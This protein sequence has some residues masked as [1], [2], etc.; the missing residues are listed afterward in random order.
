MA[1]FEQ[2]YLV[3]GLSASAAVGVLPTVGAE[4]IL[5]LIALSLPVV[6]VLAF[7]KDRPQPALGWA[8]LTAGFGVLAAGELLRLLLDDRSAAAP[9]VLSLIAD[10]VQLVGLMMI[11]RSR[12]TGRSRSSW[13]DAAGVGVATFTAVWS[14]VHRQLRD[15]ADW[16]SV[17]WFSTLL[18]P[19]LGVALVAMAL[20][21]VLGERGGHRVFGGLAIAYALQT[22]ADIAAEQ[23]TH[24]GWLRVIGVA[25]ALAYVLFDSSLMR[26]G[27]L[28][29]PQQSPS[30]LVRR[31]AVQALALQGAVIVVAITAIVV[32]ARSLVPMPL[33]ASWATVG[34]V[35]LVLNR[36][37]VLA[38]IRM[39]GE[40]S[41]TENHRRLTALVDNSSEIIA[42]ADPDGVL[43]Y[44][45]SSVGAITGRPAE[46]WLGSN[47][48]TVL[49]EYLVGSEV[50]IDRLRSLMP[51]ERF[52]WESE[53]RAH[54]SS[55][56]RVLKFT[57][58]NHV[59]TPEVNGWVITAS[60]VTD[61]ARLTSE[62]RHQALHDTL[63]GLPNRALLFDRIEHALERARHTDH[64]VTSVALVDLDEFK[65]VNDSLGHDT[66]DVLL[67]D[68]AARLL[69]AVRPGDTVARLGGDEFALLMEGTTEAEALAIAQRAL[70]GLALPIQLGTV[71]F[72]ANAS[73]GLVCHRGSATPME[74][75][76]FAD[77]A[78][79]EAKRE[80]KA[81]VKVFREHMHNA[82]KNQLEMRMQL[83]AAIEHDELSVVYQPIVDTSEFRVCGVEALLRWT[84]PSRG[85]V[86]PSV[87]IPVAE[88]SGLLEQIGE[89]VLRKAC[90]D[91]ARWSRRVDAAYISVNVSAAQISS[92]GF[93]GK[94]MGALDHS[95]LPPSR[96]LLEVTETML[97][98]DDSLA[99][100]VLVQ[101]RQ[102]GVRIA[103][104]D[105][106]TGYSS[107]A[108][109]RQ[110]AVDV[111]K[112]DQTFVRD[113]DTNSDHQA[114]TRTMLTLASGL[115]MTAI[116]EGVETTDELAELRRMGC[117]YA[118]GYLFSYPVPADVLALLID[119]CLLDVPPV[120]VG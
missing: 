115:S 42:L 93:V 88:Q 14:T 70:G 1:R 17:E 57:V 62:L 100:E 61:E 111:V 43:R 21:L 106:G 16:R 25:W 84:H 77:I 52:T 34:L 75:L 58:V 119:D 118:Q 15:T 19:V 98:D 110:L 10:S 91:A 13:L 76:R 38:L 8:V 113:L 117:G 50:E 120:G 24:T 28:R 69:R 64:L 41:A 54:D 112:I 36:L 116:A 107:L 31:E 51:G 37:R 85:A 59:G 94:V 49:P 80:G 26:R 105:F 60:D 32:R 92:R 109:L 66:G 114:L 90:A 55:A 27:R 104:D 97:V 87:F 67:Q 9:T 95:G 40:A 3:V 103:I 72:T 44:V 86:P 4:L 56:G 23:V 7:R 33:L 71:D 39:V 18:E 79:Y 96:L 47:V 22:G 20:R 12:T 68:V 102:L 29:P 73:I 108:Y 46:S 65:S 2:R 99:S 74:L 30:V 45:S 53:L 82:A 89:W 101:L 83:A 35:L 48:G 63:T 78:M 6:G 81:R 11:I 5:A